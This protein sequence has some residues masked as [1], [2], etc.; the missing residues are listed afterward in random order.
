M[1]KKPWE[2]LPQVWKTESAF[3]TY[4]KGVIRKGWNFHPIK[5]EYIKR[6]RVMI[7]NPNPKGSK[8][9][10]W[11]GKCEICGN[12]FKAGDMHVDHKSD[13]TAKLVKQEDIQSCFEKLM[14]VVFD[15]LRW[16]CKGCHLTHSVAQ[17]QG[18]TFDG[19]KEYQKEIAFK[20]LSAQKQKETLLKYYEQSTIGKVESKRV[21]QYREAIKN[22]V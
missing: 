21:E 6:N 19:A 16:I 22:A 8:K 2:E 7:P 15:D 14:L 10:V 20:K 3:W 17:K 5:L 1:P 13:E 11:G 18:M 9:E 4:C 12:T